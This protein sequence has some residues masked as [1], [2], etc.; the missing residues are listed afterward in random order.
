MWQSIVIDAQRIERIK[1]MSK[2]REKSAHIHTTDSICYGS[3]TVT[4]AQS[5]S[6]NEMLKNRL[7][8]TRKFPRVHWCCDNACNATEF[9]CN[10]SNC[11]VPATT[12]SVSHS[13]MMLF[14]IRTIKLTQA[15]CP[16]SLLFCL[17]HLSKRI[18]SFFDGPKKFG[19][20][21]L[22]SRKREIETKY[23]K[24]YKWSINILSWRCTFCR[25][26]LYCTVQS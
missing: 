24:N 14:T 23:I 2:R 13:I 6:N 1:K 9:K 25:L 8:W 3:F 22:M 19:Q 12:Q 17:S 21:I 16:F 10:A 26:L 11:A 7:K 15:Q 5:I 20:S 4:I 18:S